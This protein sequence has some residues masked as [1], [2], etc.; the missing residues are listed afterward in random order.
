MGSHSQYDLIIFDCD[1][2]LVD[3]ETL[4]NQIVCDMLCEQGFPQF[5]MAY[6]LTHFVGMRFSKILEHVHE[7][8]GTAL[9][10]SLRQEY[11]QRVG[12]RLKTDLKPVP[13]AKDMI[14]AA[15]KK[16][17]ICVVS[18]G[19]RNNVLNGLLHTGL[20]DF[21]P[22][23]HVFSGLMAPNPKPAPDLFLMAIDQLGYS[24]QQSIAIE[25]S[26]SGVKGAVAAGI[27]TIGFTGTHH[28]PSEHKET[29]LSAG[30]AD[31]IHKLDDFHKYY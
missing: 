5:D 15:Q 25:D 29:L 4:N 1:G 7:K 21:F 3:S 19:E 10:Q 12:E 18:N 9:P 24:V 22:D 13:G 20:K 17:E 14:I 27:Q 16:A 11:V 6:A 2:T 31:V 23:H 28:S 26:V 8:T 30:A